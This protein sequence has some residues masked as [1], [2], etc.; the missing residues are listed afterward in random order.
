M[1]KPILDAK[2]DFFDSAQPLGRIGTTADMAGLALFLC[3]RASAHIT[4]A[5][6]PIDGGQ[7]LA[8]SAISRLSVFVKH[9]AGQLVTLNGND[10][11]MDASL[12]DLG[13]DR[14]FSIAGKV[15]VVTGGGTGIGK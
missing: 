3:S 7:A 9:A 2:R 11:A 5:V 15:A 1:V 10:A 14:L 4:G 13:I 12:D 8:A 6:I